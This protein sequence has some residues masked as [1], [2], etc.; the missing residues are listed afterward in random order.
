MTWPG[1]QV[2]KAF[3]AERPRATIRRCAYCGWP[4]VGYA[5]KSHMDLAAKE[6][7]NN[8]RSHDEPN[9]KGTS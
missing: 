6:P 8:L 2:V 1:K 9:Q 7:H 3:V 4:C 5:C